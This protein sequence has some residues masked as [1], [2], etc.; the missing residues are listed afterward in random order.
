MLTVLARGVYPSAPIY[1]LYVWYHANFR[2]RVERGEAF[3]L[4][5]AC[6]VSA[7]AFGRVWC[8]FLPVLLKTVPGVARVR[9]KT[10]KRALIFVTNDKFI[11]RHGSPVYAHILVH[12]VYID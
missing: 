1:D 8:F 11:N 4:S 2:A 6:C 3:F 10:K 5:L 12:L 9:K 7:F